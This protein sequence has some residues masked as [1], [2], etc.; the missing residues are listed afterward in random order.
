MKTRLLIAVLVS[1]VA[2]HALAQQQPAPLRK[3]VRSSQ[4]FTIAPGGSF[5]LDNPIGNIEVV[6]AADVT[7]VQ[8]AITTILTA[9][10]D[11]ALQEAR[12]QSGMLVGG[13]MKTRVVRT[14]ITAY[15]EKK[16]WSA[17]VHWTVR[18]PKSVNVR[19]VS[20]ASGRIRVADVT[21]NVHVKNF[22]GNVT[23]ANVT[24]ATFVESV[25]GSIVYTTPQPRANVVLS[26][27]NGHITATVA[28]TADFRWVA[29]AATGDIRTNLIPRGKFAGATF[30]GNVNAPGGPTI[31]MNS[32]M[33][34]LHL[35][36][37]GSSAATSQSIKQAAPLVASIGRPR[38]GQ[39]ITPANSP[40]MLR[41]GTVK[42]LTHNTTL[43]DVK[44]NEVRGDANV[45]TGAG[46]VHLGSVTGSA[47]VV[48]HGGPLTLGE[49][50][51][52]LTASTRAGDILVDSTRRGGTISTEGGTIRLL[53][54]S[55]PTRLSSG[56]GDIIVR[57]A[58]APVNAETASGDVSIT[59]DPASKS[60]AVQAKTGKGN[61]VLNVS[62]Q[63]SADLD[64][65]ILTSDPNADT[66]L[67]DIPGLSISR[68]QVGSRTRVR[69]TGKLNGG[70]QK[71]VLQATSGDI[72][73]ATG[74]VGPTIVKPR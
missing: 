63:F 39:T 3:T 49:V 20:G 57:Q 36:A 47:N 61:I 4:T 7:D 62:P 66:F 51:G 2:G 21:G 68:E 31:T 8:A 12:R 19:V 32:L 38:T 54:T 15:Q 35:L 58:A 46:E 64:A 25:N 42:Q 69:A 22:N 65:T 9:P 30:V 40:R 18:V 72:R 43:G 55:G 52:P 44:V 53:Y 37:S 23:L 41:L 60:E 24:G 27:V 71:V 14:A 5:V 70:G 29:E 59:I 67:S 48:S 1:A 26:T 11:A 13:D 10:N 73:I 17:I 28:P 50:L 45:T 74:R 33:G 16:P 6:G 34:D 56:G